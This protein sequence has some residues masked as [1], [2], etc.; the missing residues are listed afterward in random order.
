MSNVRLETRQLCDSLS[1]SVN[2]GLNEGECNYVI[3]LINAWRLHEYNLLQVSRI[4][5][6]VIV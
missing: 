6:E 1:A 3:I 4:M 5:S 2:D